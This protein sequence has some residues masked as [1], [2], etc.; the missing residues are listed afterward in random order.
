MTKLRWQ[1]MGEVVDSGFMPFGKTIT[2][3]DKQILLDWV[4]TCALPA[5]AMGCE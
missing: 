3:A 5:D 4:S 2:P 1:R